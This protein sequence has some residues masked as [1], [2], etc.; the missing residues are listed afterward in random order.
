[1]KRIIIIHCWGGP[2]DG[3]WYPWLRD[4]LEQHEIA[5]EIPEMPDPES[6][7]IEE[8]VSHLA[9]I[10]GSP[11]EDTFLVGH[12]IG[13]QTILRYLESIDAK[14]GGALLVAGWFHLNGLSPE[15]QAIA[16]E[17]LETKIDINAASAS[18]PYMV[19][20]FSNNDPHVPIE[21]AKLFEDFSEV[22]ILDDYGHFDEVEELAIA[23]EQV[24]RMVNNE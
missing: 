3:F 7:R 15:E 19:S 21:D 5:V 20:L 13:C 23:Y 4:Q 16:K 17:W 24:M 1:M 22:K 9:H 12:S 11:N 18:C 10:I 14:I 6:P 2:A 8:W